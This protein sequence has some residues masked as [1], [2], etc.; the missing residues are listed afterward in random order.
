MTG[1]Q[2]KFYN[3]LRSYPADIICPMK[4]EIDP[5][6]WDVISHNFSYLASALVS[7][8]KIDYEK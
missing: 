7:I 2:Q 3:D 4:R 1:L 8:M 6:D 5:K